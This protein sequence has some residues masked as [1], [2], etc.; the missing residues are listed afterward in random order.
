ML[1]KCYSLAAVQ[2]S[3]SQRTCCYILQTILKMVFNCTSIWV[4]AY[5]WD[6]KILGID[7]EDEPICHERPPKTMKQLCLSSAA[8]VVVLG[9]ME[10]YF[11]KP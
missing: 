10:N 1:Q 7:V 4:F 6:M 5:E 3:G 11:K 2:G 9:L 8:A